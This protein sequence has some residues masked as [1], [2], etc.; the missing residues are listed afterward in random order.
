MF[1]AGLCWL[2]SDDVVGAVRALNDYSEL[3]CTFA[4]SS[5]ALF[6]R[7]IVH[8]LNTSNLKAFKDAIVE[9]DSIHKLDSNAVEL[10]LSIQKL[11]DDSSNGCED[12]GDSGVED[13]NVDKGVINNYDDSNSDNVGDGVPAISSTG[14]EVPSSIGDSNPINGE[15]GGGDDD[16]L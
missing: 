11:I 16:L 2:A 1:K 12:D 10:L 9:Y 4:P 15:D 7:Q 13:N 3:D 14:G 5:E 8:S 6:L